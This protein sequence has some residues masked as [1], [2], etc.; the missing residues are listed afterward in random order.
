MGFLSQRLSDYAYL[1][2]YGDRGQHFPAAAQTRK[3]SRWLAQR[4]GGVGRAEI[5]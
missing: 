3:K 2:G 1:Y 5:T 4:L